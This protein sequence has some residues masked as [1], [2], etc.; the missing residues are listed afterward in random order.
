MKWFLV[1]AFLAL[2]TGLAWWWFS[3]P[4]SLSD[5]EF[6][7]LYSEP[8]PPRRPEAV[9]HLGHSLVGR[10]MPN[11]LSRFMGNRYNS[12]L[13]WGGAI[14]QHW[15]RDVPGFEEENRPPVFRDAHEAIGSGEYEAVVFTEMVELKDAI[16]WHDS[17]NALAKWAQLARKARPDVR[18]YLYETWHHLDDPAGW[19][20]RIA[21]D[22]P[23][24]W[25]GEILRKAMAQPGVG[26]IHV[27][28][29]GQ[30]MAAVAARIEAG[31]LPGLTRREELFYKSPEGVQDYI[32]ASDLGGYIV[33][34]T[35][36]AVLSGESPVGL[37]SDL[38][39]TDG[40]PARLPPAETAR[41][42]QQVVWDVVSRYAPAGIGH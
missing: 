27:I 37:P 33:A 24:L 12:Q 9:Y 17:A 18:L 40:S 36:F 5:A 15:L 10:E 14:N 6:N 30:V 2:A 11:M 25:E 31:A 35:H 28:P 13:G 20:T 4:R 1:L 21:A 32:H 34:L 42:I 7:A 22:L 29:A 41:A 26:T 16:R 8:L 23:A 39:N 3:P 19:E 38:L